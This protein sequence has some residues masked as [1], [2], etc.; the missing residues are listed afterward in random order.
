MEGKI[1]NEF[2]VTVAFPD[3]LW[4]TGGKSELPGVR[5]NGIG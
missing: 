1:A 2:F 4:Y 5:K 3:K